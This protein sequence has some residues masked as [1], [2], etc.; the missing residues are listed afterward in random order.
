MDRDEAHE[1][2]AYYQRRSAEDDARH[3]ATIK[4]FNERLIDRTQGLLAAASKPRLSA[5]SFREG[6]VAGMNKMEA[7]V[8]NIPNVPDLEQALQLHLNPKTTG[9]A[10]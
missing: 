10:K 7:A 2:I 8:R 5:K 9:H 6:F 1:E 3:E 4:E